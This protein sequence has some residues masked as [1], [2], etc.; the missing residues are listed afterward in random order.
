MASDAS[1]YSISKDVDVV[2]MSILFFS[3]PKRTL[4]LLYWDHLLVSQGT[5]SCLSVGGREENRPT[6][7]KLNLPPRS[8]FNL[9]SPNF[10]TSYLSIIQN[11]L[12]SPEIIPNPIQNH[13]CSPHCILTFI[14]LQLKPSQNGRNQPEDA[15]SHLPF[16]LS[17]HLHTPL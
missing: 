11:H 6:E 7:R 10:P 2:F 1:K 3:E 8:N 9:S 5:N 12:F 4:I 16:F 14:Q 13:L 17:A 15:I